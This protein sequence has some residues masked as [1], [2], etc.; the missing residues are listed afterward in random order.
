MN[1]LSC[2]T[3]SGDKHTN[4]NIKET[5][6]SAKLRTLKITAS[7]GDWFIF[8]PDKGRGEKKLMSPLLAVGGGHQHHRACDAVIVMLKQ[9]G[10]QIIFVELKS[11]SPSGYVGQ[12]QSTR[13]F[14]KYIF[15][16]LNEFNNISFPNIEE[17]FIVFHTS[18]TKKILLNKLPTKLKAFSKSS[19][20]PMYPQK[21]LVTDGQTIYL[22]QF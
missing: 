16:L 3:Y 5:D 15:G 12:F 6:P 10:L 7:N 9:V 13:Q 4:A 20:D 22:N 18:K 14:T 8:S 1:K 17:R 21:E 11:N 19:N 2:V